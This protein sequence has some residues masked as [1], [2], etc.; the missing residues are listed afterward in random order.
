MKFISYQERRNKENL[1]IRRYNVYNFLFFKIKKKVLPVLGENNKIILGGREVTE[2]DKK[3]LDKVGKIT[4]EGSDNIVEIADINELSCHI[5]IKGH[6]NTI[7]MGGK[8]IEKKGHSLMTG[9]KNNEKSVTGVIV[10]DSNIIKLT[11]INHLTFKTL[12]RGNENKINIGKFNANT[13]LNVTGM[14]GNH[15]ELTIEDSERFIAECSFRIEGDNR[16]IHIGKNCMF[17]VGVIIWTTDFHPIYDL[18]TSKRINVEKDIIIG[19]NVWIGRD[20]YILKGSIV[21]SGCIVGVRSV[22]TKAFTKENCIIAGS[23]AKVVKEN[24]HWE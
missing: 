13:V 9:E 19:D 18:E 5:K 2:N 17:S 6:N 3:F 15:K 1:L 16:K 7:I 10:G 4:I 23:S 12:L 22:V 14:S 11:D 21:P 24:I 8:H 20:V